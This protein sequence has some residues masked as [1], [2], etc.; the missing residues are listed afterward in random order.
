MS[1]DID[2]ILE[3]IDILFKDGRYP[4]ALEKIE[5]TL[6]TLWHEDFNPE[7][8]LIF[9]IKKLSVLVAA[10]EFDSA[11][12]LAEQLTED[13]KELD[14]SLHHIDI[15]LEKALIFSNLRQIESSDECLNQVEEALNLFKRG[16]NEEYLRRKAQFNQV[17]GVHHVLSKKFYAQNE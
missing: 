7:V 2:N 8:I 1:G 3:E 17:K 11:Q 4:I 9:N 6:E 12:L 5:D 13:I 15:L 14:I 10:N 16:D